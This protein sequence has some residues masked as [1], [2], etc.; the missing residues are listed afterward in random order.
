MYKIVFQLKNSYELAKIYVLTT[1]T[2]T[3]FSLSH[4]M[5]SENAPICIHASNNR[6][7]KQL[8]QKT[9]YNTNLQKHFLFA[10]HRQIK[11]A[12]AIKSSTIS[13]T[14][15][16]AVSVS[17]ACCEDREASWLSFFM[18]SSTILFYFMFLCFVITWLLGIST[19]TRVF[20]YRL[21][22]L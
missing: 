22:S 5:L 20:S 19:V 4:A 21:H 7:K 1:D 14:I 17:S 18:R 13:V 2:A 6:K 8:I 16:F 15:S 12:P 11:N 9:R 3:F 10:D